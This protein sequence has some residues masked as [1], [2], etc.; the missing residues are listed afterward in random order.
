MGFS[1]KQSKFF[2]FYTGFVVLLG[3]SLVFMGYRKYKIGNTLREEAKSSV[4][5]SYC[6]KVPI[7]E[8]ERR[9]NEL[10]RSELRKLE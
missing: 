6:E 4:K 10:T 1:I 8:Y 7:R 3:L 9:K 5:K 2:A